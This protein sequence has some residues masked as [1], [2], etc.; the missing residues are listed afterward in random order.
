MR[1]A[2]SPIFIATSL[3]FLYYGKLAA[4]NAYIAVGSL[5]GY[6]E[7]CGCSPETDFGG[8]RRLARFV[9]FHRSLDK[10]L[11]LWNLGDNFGGDLEKNRAIA[12]SLLFLKPTVSLPEVA[13][14]AA[15]WTPSL[16][17]LPHVLSTG[18]NPL[19]IPAKP[20]QWAGNYAVFGAIGPLSDEEIESLKH[21]VQKIAPPKSLLLFRGN[22]ATLKTLIAADL[23]NRII[24]SNHRTHEAPDLLE[25]EKPGI[26]LRQRQVA[27]VP[28]FGQ[29]V[30]VSQLR[31]KASLL[32]GDP[33]KGLKKPGHVFP[34]LSPYRWLTVKWK[35]GPQTQVDSI[36]DHYISGQQKN[37]L[38]LVNRWKKENKDH[39][40]V[41]S[42]TCR[43]CHLKEFKVWQQSQHSLAYKTLE[44]QGKHELADCVSC[45][46]VGFE[47][48]AFR[49]RKLSSH[50]EGVGCENCH[51]PGKLHIANPQNAKLSRNPKMCQKC[52]H[53]PHM[54]NFDFSAYWPRI[55]H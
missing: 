14:Q 30:L 41:G 2:F 52:H 53:P 19:K 26:L 15:A 17:K 33:Q 24:T 37:F 28:S 11:L 9:D 27:A 38:S 44:K 16:Q 29:G 51:G 54:A 47:V 8:L 20:M 48:G 45:H 40:Y 55:A 42:A 46:V 4:S 23:F 35:K 39:N 50:L 49:G 7:S 22:D 3:A 34:V 25:M 6:V 5:K 18:R 21:L 12:E 1:F 32:F 43:S 31:E 36:M 10:E 13:P